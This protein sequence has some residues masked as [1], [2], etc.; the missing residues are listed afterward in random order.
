MVE[1]VES[2]RPMIALKAK[3]K[4]INLNINVED[5]QADLERKKVKQVILNLLNNAINYTADKG[6]VSLE[7]THEEKQL[8]IIVSDSG[9]GID[10]E[11]IPRLF[12]RFYR[13]D[14]ARSR[15]TGGTGLGLAIVKHDVELHDRHIKIDSK[16]RESLSFQITMQ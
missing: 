7:V 3:E 15:N 13:V 8:Y 16:L 1:L 12:E 4:S 9:I 2:I 6:E 11:L 14:Q 5:V 10:Q